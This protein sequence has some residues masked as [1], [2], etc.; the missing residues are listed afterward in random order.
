MGLD[1][2][3]ARLHPVVEERDW[4]VARGW[5]LRVGGSVGTIRGMLLFWTEL[6]MLK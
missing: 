5:F 3:P 6:V 1:P 4:R 2:S